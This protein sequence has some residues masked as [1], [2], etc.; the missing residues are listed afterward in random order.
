MPRLCRYYHGSSRASSRFA[1]WQDRRGY[2]IEDPWSEP[3]SADEDE[4]LFRC[5]EHSTC[6]RLLMRAF[7]QIND[8]AIVINRFFHRH[9]HQ[10]SQGLN[11]GIPPDI[12]SPT[13]TF[14]SATCNLRS[15]TLK[16]RWSGTFLLGFTNVKHKILTV[17]W[18]Q[19]Q[20]STDDGYI[21]STA[22]IDHLAVLPLHAPQG[23]KSIFLF[24]VF[25]IWYFKEW[26]IM[27]MHA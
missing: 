8:G 1:K 27:R 13:L 7:R 19:C 12:S 3:R 10:S 26:S 11:W 20:C 6:C 23:T 17:R 5:P 2:E 24:D 15:T 25:V 4:G 9:T 18:I 14:R 16:Y 21:K 22:G